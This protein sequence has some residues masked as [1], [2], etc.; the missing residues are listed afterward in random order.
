MASPTGPSSLSP[1]PSPSQPQP[2]SA[3]E[4]ENDDGNE[5][6]P[7]VVL[8]RTLLTCPEA[9]VYRVPPLRTSGGHRAEQWDLSDPLE[10][11][12]LVVK[13]VD[14][15]LHL[16]LW[17]ERPRQGGPKGATEPHLFAVAKIELD[18]GAPAGGNGRMERWVEP[19][20]DSSRYSV[21]RIA[22]ERTGREALIGL[23]F[24]ERSD[25]MGFKMA[26]QEYEQSLRRERDA[27][28]MRKAYESGEGRDNGGGGADVD[29]DADADADGGAPAQA[30]SSLTLGDGEKIR[31]NL[32]GAAG[33]GSRRSRSKAR[34][35]ARP[36]ARPPSGEAGGG[37][38]LL[39]KPPKG[40]GEGGEKPPAP[41]APAAAAAAAA[42]A[43]GDR[44]DDSD[45]DDEFGDFESGS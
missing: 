31:L 29:A 13:R 9:F 33:E 18:V 2:Q 7:R 8:E 35:K 32:G 21:V 28:R 1:S 12:S 30:A 19:V 17:A 10:T 22:D 39:R 38:L 42:A 43:D 14:D 37:G 25:A 5:N 11:C 41:P 26:L 34:S 27:E 36:K 16:S 6:E 44:G 15:R 40:V 4:N 23:G 20:A 45:D 3:N 24:R